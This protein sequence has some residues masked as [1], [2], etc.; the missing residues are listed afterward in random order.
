MQNGQLLS[1]IAHIE[2]NRNLLNFLS[3]VLL[4]KSENIYF[5]NVLVDL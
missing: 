5:G 1:I 4:K 3:M 2:R